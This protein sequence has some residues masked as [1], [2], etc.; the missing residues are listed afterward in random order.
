MKKI[1]ILGSLLFTF[2]M[3]HAECL[4][5]ND[6]VT[7]EGVLSKKAV[8]IK[9]ADF[10]WV[11]KNGFVSYT[12][13]VLTKPICFSEE[14]VTVPSTYTL[15]TSTPDGVTDDQL[16]EGVKVRMTGSVFSSHTAHHYQQLLINADNVEVI[17]E[18]P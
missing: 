7:V 1:M 15:Q 13:I 10:G 8:Y 16:E 6:T 4:R 2:V 11:P 5:G 14:D 18:N 9:P 3:A 12:T 17:T